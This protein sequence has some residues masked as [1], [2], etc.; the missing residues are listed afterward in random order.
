MG[1][2]YSTNHFTAG[3]GHLVTG[4][5]L[6]KS[7]VRPKGVVRLLKGL[8]FVPFKLGFPHLEYVPIDR[9]VEARL[10]IT[11]KGLIVAAM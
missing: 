11:P 2:L 1:V 4:N 9:Y 3:G 8:L 6:F 5:L 10:R 7:L